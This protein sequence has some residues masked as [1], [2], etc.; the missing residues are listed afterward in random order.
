MSVIN[1][2]KPSD[3]LTFNIQNFYMV[4]ALRSVFC[5]DLRTDNDF[6]FIHHKLIGFYNRSG[7]CLQRGTD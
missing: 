3:Y 6:C 2:L 1:V 7:K 5:T 4:F